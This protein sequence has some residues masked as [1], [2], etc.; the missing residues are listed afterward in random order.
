MSMQI[1][2]IGRVT[3]EVEVSTTQSGMDIAKFSVVSNIK[4][5]DKEVSTFVN[6][7]VFGDAIERVSKGIK[8]GSVLEVTGNDFEGY[9]KKSGDGIGYSAIYSSH[10]YVPYNSPPGNAP[11]TEGTKPKASGFAGGGG[12]AKRNARSAPKAS[13][14][15]KDEQLNWDS[16]ESV[17][18]DGEEDAP[19]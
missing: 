6:F 16:N 10:R 8:K 7:S 11:Q 12:G 1:S 13:A 4:K 17:S 5:R 18:D 15:T 9:I 2:I 19:F 3:S 14:S